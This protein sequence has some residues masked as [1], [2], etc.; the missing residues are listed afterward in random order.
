M[1]YQRGELLAMLI[2]E[3]VR[4]RSGGDR[5]LDDLMLD[6]TRRARGGEPAADPEWVL[7]WIAERSSDE[8]ADQIRRLVEKGGPVPLPDRLSEA[9]LVLQRGEDGRARYVS[10]G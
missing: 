6:L 10:P 1:L 7:A 3:E 5:S 9:G 2:D 4:A 8:F